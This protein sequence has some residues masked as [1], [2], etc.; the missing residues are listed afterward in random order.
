MENEIYEPT[1]KLTQFTSVPD[2][3]ESARA[4]RTKS[5]GLKCST[6][7][8]FAD[9]ALGGGL[10][11]SDLLLIAAEP[12]VGKSELSLGIAAHNAAEGKRVHMFSLES[13]SNEVTHRLFY[14]ELAD[15]YYASTVFRP[16]MLGRKLNY[17]DWMDGRFEDS[18]KDL[19]VQVEEIIKEKYKTLN[20]FY[21]GRNFGIE[22]LTREV[23]SAK[24]QSDLIVLDHIHYM[25]I[26]PNENENRAMTE[27]VKAIRDIALICEK[28]FVI[29]A[30]VRKR[31]S[32]LKGLLP[33]LEDIHGS[34][35]LSK[36]ATKA[37]VLAPCFDPTH[38]QGEFFTYMRVAKNRRDGSRCRFTAVCTF[39]AFKNSYKNEF[40]M[41]RL[42][43]GGQE[44]ERL[45]DED[46]PHWIKD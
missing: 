36:I 12:G 3:L 11:P 8:R 30:H 39:D 26:S 13:E 24:D 19:E 20:V 32:R 10:Y 7:I 23:L 42:T 31:D 38:R 18:L 22:D 6:G 21:R 1:S 44:F 4:A 40:V 34:S 5:S 43:K 25:D 17:S 33:D 9:K 16:S 37:L 29:V 35:N 14:R 28:P 45:K 15:L 41:G 46:M 2:S 27:M